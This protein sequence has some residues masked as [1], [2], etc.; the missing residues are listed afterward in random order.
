MFIGSGRVTNNLGLSVMSLC[1]IGEIL[2][3][4]CALRV[5]QFQDGCFIMS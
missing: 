4:H 3:A 1:S 2:L 5:I